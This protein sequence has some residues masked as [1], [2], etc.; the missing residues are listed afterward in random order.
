MFD[1]HGRV[2]VI[3]GG[4][5]GLGVL[6]ANALAARGCDV[7]LAARRFEILD[8]NAQALREQ[9]GVKAIPV[10][11]DV[12][13]EDQVIAARELVEKEFG[14]CDILINCAGEGHNDWAIDLALEKWQATIDVCVTGLFLMCREFGKLMREHNYGRIVNVA[15]MLGMIALDSSFGRGI[16]EYSASKGAVINFTRQL[17]NEWA[18]YGITVNTLSPGFFA[19]EQSPVGQGWFADFI[20]TWCPMKRNG[21]DHELDAAIIF[22]TCEENSYMTGNNVVIDGGWTCTLASFSP[23]ATIFKTDPAV[24]TSTAGSVFISLQAPLYSL[25]VQFLCAKTQKEIEVAPVTPNRLR[26]ILAN[27]NLNQ[28]LFDSTLHLH[29]YVLLSM[30][31][32][33]WPC[34]SQ[35][36][37][38]FPAGNDV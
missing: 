38:C 24:E 34:M 16:S 14:R 20:N 26:G 5:S 28:I 18:Q 6:C 7:V 12:T 1:Y 19:S 31:Q 4:S 13:K 21:S 9:Y 25:N 10:R 2:A 30:S 36:T 22:M 32:Q 27:L 3:T 33:R 8:K 29:T 11:C 23:I 15:S 17:A 37:P 35:L